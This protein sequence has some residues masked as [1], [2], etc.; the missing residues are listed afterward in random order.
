MNTDAG[1][2][3]EEFAVVDERFF[4]ASNSTCGSHTLREHQIE[5]FK[6]D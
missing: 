6:I 2:F 4:K 1:C 3:A 5:A